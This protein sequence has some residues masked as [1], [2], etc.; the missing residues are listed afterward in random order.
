MNMHHVHTHL[1]VAK[2]EQEDTS[3]REQH[4]SHTDRQRHFLDYSVNINWTRLY[5]ACTSLLFQI[6]HSTIQHQ[7]TPQDRYSIAVFKRLVRD[8]SQFRLPAP[9]TAHTSA[10]RTG[11]SSGP[12]QSSRLC[13]TSQQGRSSPHSQQEVWVGMAAHTLQFRLPAPHTAHTSEGRT[14]SWAGL[15]EARTSHCP[16]HLRRSAHIPYSHIQQVA[17]C[18]YPPLSWGRSCSLRT[19]TGR[20]QQQAATVASVRGTTT[21]AGTVHVRQARSTSSQTC[22]ASQHI[23]PAAACTTPG[24][25]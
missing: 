3:Q 7:H 5:K 23:P 12:G 8:T 18:R 14:G 2:Q 9:H 25:Q 22:T 4:T 17:E 21:T 24:S 10:G 16:C 6:T 13:K 20:S 19:S 15:E 1:I 11:W